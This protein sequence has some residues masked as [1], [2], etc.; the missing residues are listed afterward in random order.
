MRNG[1]IR[2]AA[3]LPRVKVAD[4]GYNKERI[5]ELIRQAAEQGVKIMVFPELCITGYTCG[6]LFYQELLLREA[7]KALFEIAEMTRDLDAVVFVGL[8]VEHQAKLY[9][10]AAALCG[11]KILGLVPKT[12][13]PTYNEFYERRHFAKG[14]ETPVEVRLDETHVVPMGTRLL[15]SCRQMPGL[16]MGAEI[17]EDLWAP[18]PPSIGH[19]MAGATVI[20]NLSASD[21]TTGKDVYRKKPGQRTVGAADLRLCLL[22]RRGWG[23]HPGCGLLRT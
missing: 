11:G 16:V 10:V 19:A 5:C 13:I 9:N 6:D 8:P 14:M 23:I 21:E 15:F 18:D 3:L 7:K 22:Q 20:V 1:F 2:A 4:P 12:H 17:C